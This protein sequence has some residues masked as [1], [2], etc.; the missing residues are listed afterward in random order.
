MITEVRN[1]GSLMRRCVFVVL[2]KVSVPGVLSLPV[3]LTESDAKQI[4]V[5]Q[6]SRYC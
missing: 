2:Q 3:P 4:N 5:R 1:V 6:S